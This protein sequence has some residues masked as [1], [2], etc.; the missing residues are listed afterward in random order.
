M[1]HI[2]ISGTVT[3][4]NQINTYVVEHIQFLNPSLRYQQD[5]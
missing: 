5:E 1:G 4:I 3:V 2:E